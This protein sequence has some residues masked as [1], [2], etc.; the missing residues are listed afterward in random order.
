MLATKCTARQV[1]EAV[2]LADVMKGGPFDADGFKKKRC[3]ARNELISCRKS[4]GVLRAISCSTVVRIQ[5]ATIPKIHCAFPHQNVFGF[6]AMLAGIVGNCSHVA[7]H[8]SIHPK[9]NQL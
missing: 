3:D 1:K 4:D 6:Q 9:T 2:V 7:Q 5:F 8:E